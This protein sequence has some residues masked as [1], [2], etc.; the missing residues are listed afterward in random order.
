MSFCCS[1]FVVLFFVFFFLR[2]CGAVL[3]VIPAVCMLQLYSLQVLGWFVFP[4]LPLGCSV[5]D[6]S[7]SPCRHFINESCKHHPF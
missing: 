5:G 3:F 1:G 2:G 4:V 7:G 6:T